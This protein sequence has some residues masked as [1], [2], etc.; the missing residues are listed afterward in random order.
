MANSIWAGQRVRKVFIDEKTVS[1]RETGVSQ[2]LE[3]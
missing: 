3:I 1:H 2:V